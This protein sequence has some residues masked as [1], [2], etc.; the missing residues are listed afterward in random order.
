MARRLAK[1]EGIFV[2][3]S[4]GSAIA[5]L[6]Q[7]KDQL[8][9]D[10]LVV[11][12]FHDHGSRYV[13]KIFNDDWMRE[14]QFLDDEELLVKDIIDRKKSK[15]FVTVDKDATLGEASKIMREMNI[16][17]IPVTNGGERVIGSITES[18]IL[19]TL[20]ENPYNK[21]NAVGSVM[22]DSFPMVDIY[23]SLQKITS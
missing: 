23:D 21:A 3:Y 4:A 7:M 8:T 19:K 6:N 9:K 15:N 1:E 17:Q 16:S 2:G 20:L 11:V 10:D 14:R 13:G 5:G 22:G 18:S 12:A